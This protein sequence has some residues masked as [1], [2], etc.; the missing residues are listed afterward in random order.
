MYET[1]YSVWPNCLKG[2]VTL[3][4]DCEHACV[5]QCPIQ[6]AVC[7]PPNHTNATKCFHFYTVTVFWVLV[8]RCYFGDGKND[9]LAGFHVGDVY[10]SPLP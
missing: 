2:V 1:S 7:T 6:V 3:D 8:S 5:C 10:G 9:H 4:T